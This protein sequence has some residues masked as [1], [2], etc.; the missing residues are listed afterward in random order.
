MVGLS[1][2]DRLSADNLDMM[3]LA[4]IFCVRKRKV[5]GPGQLP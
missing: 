2:L 3:V 5:I 4:K 1:W